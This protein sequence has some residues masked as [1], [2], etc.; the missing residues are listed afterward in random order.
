MEETKE[1]V[2]YPPLAPWLA[3]LPLIADMQWQEP[4]S[5]GAFNRKLHGIV[6]YGIYRGFNHRITGADSLVVGDSS[7]E[8]TAVVRR[9][10]YTLTVQGQHGVSLSIPRNKT[11]IAVI[12]AVYGFELLTKQVSSDS[13]VDAAKIRLIEPGLVQDHHIRLFDVHLPS[14]ENLAEKHI[15]ISKRTTSGFGMGEHENKR[16]PHPQYARNDNAATDDDIDSGATAEKHVNLPQ[17]WRAID[18]R[19]QFRTEAE[20]WAERAINRNLFKKSG[21]VS[22]IVKT[23]NANGLVANKL[24]LER[25]DTIHAAGFVFEGL[26]HVKFSPAENGCRTFNNVTGDSAAHADPNI[27][28]AYADSSVLIDVV[29]NRVDVYGDEICIEE[30]TTKNPYVYAGGRIHSTPTHIDGVPTTRSNRPA[31]Y[32][33]MYLGDTGSVGTS[34]N[35]LTATPEQ[36]AAICQNPKNWIWKSP[37]NR[38]FQARPR[39]RAFCGAGNGDWANIDC[40]TGQ[41]LE[42]APGVPVLSCNGQ[43]YVASS[44]TGLFEDGAGSYFLVGG[45]VGRFNQGSLH[46]ENLMGASSVKVPGKLF[47]AHWNDSRV[48]GLIR[49]QKDCFIHA[50]TLDGMIGGAGRLI[51]GRYFNAIY[52]SGLGGVADRRDTARFTHPKMATQEQA[53]VGIDNQSTS[54][55]L[56]VF[57]FF[58]KALAIPKTVTGWWRH[59]GMTVYS[60]DTDNATVEVEG[61]QSS[62]TNLIGRIRFRNR[63]TN[64]AFNLDVDGLGMLKWM[65]KKLAFDAD[66]AN[67]GHP[68][69]AADITSG[70]IADDRLPAAGTDVP[71]IVQL[72]ASV[73]STSTKLGAAA[74]GLKAV[75]DLVITKSPIGHAHD[76]DYYIKHTSDLLLA[77]KLDKHATADNALK[78]GNKTSAEVIK[79]ARSGLYGPDNPA[80]VEMGEVTRNEDTPIPAGMPTK[81]TWNNV[82]RDKHQW[83]DA[84]NNVYIAQKEGWYST[85]GAVHVTPQAPA[86]TYIHALVNGVLSGASRTGS[87]GAISEMTA[88]IVSC[89]LYLK[90]GDRVGLYLFT[91]AALEQNSY[92]DN[93]HNYFQ[94]KY[95]GAE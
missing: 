2:I 72:T 3:N 28:F 11:V 94:I 37:D 48:D 50:H 77:G 30:V 67:V 43:P 19:I 62:L 49:T 44:E 76:D 12:E 42:F 55:P 53:E 38:I 92:S 70:V 69:A 90:V 33:A 56:R 27:A 84:L 32:Y 24:E 21:I 66:K 23:Y 54:S 79:S 4:F 65:G 61:H 25:T 29:T 88:L 17:L 20:V 13:E 8:N 87:G 10:D 64:E 22:E 63:H 58:E 59:R 46:P 80:P 5:T 91:T 60:N 85:R 36:Q 9:G 40:S 82:S 52:P 15:D 16:H 68:H 34:V 86:T 41:P 14:G 7:G 35:L 78:L 39:R 75:Y 31:S 89:D 74:K 93:D 45:T 47:G 95:I 81:L 73:S 26:Q 18:S 83:F 51:D 57:Q 1:V 71:G 6:S